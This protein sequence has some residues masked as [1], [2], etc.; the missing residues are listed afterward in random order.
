VKVRTVLRRR[1]SARAG[2]TKL[3]EKVG[4]EATSGFIRLIPGRFLSCGN[5]RPD[6]RELRSDFL[7]FLFR[8]VLQIHHDV[9]CGGNPDQFVQF[10]LHRLRIA[11]LRALNQEYHQ[12]CDDAG[13]TVDHQLPRVGI[14]VKRAGNRPDNHHQK[15]KA[16][17][18]GRPDL[19]CNYIR[20]RSKKL[21]QSALHRRNVMQLECLMSMAAVQSRSRWTGP[22]Q[23]LG[24][25]LRDSAL[26]SDTFGLDLHLHCPEMERRFKNVDHIDCSS[27]VVFARRWGLGVFALA[28]LGVVTSA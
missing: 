24:P 13:G 16:E 1:R 8:A 11:I 6:V 20:T 28:Q 19:V 21:S 17:C 4:P 23:V 14:V 12:K 15:A 18:S 7:D 27:G 25:R 26:S 9:A 3:L 22:A 10:H 2:L 5:S